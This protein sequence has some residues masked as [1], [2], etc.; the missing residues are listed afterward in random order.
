MNSKGFTLIEILIALTIFAIVATITSS[1]LYYAFT[2]RTRVTAQMDQLSTLQ[3]TISLLQQDISQTVPRAVRGNEMHLFPAFIGRPEYVEFT[4]DG[5]NNPK[6]AEQ[7]STLKRIAWLCLNGSLI[8]RSWNRL[9]PINRNVHQDQILLH[10]VKQ[11][12]FNYL[13]QAL[14]VLHEWRPEAVT[15]NQ[16]LEPL[17][18]AVQINMT[19]N[20]WGEMNLLF[21]IP[22]ALYA[23]V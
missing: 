21:I 6:S 2:T 11:C 20:H 15:Q 19:L 17:P 10:Q 18:K 14:Q 9:D 22:E 16:K 12:H 1:S 13:N 23:P 5:N 8:R 4:R 3:L 7:R